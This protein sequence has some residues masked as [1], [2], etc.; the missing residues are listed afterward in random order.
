MRFSSYAAG[1][2]TGAAMFCLAPLAHADFAVQFV[3]NPTGNGIKVQVFDNGTTSI[4]SLNGGYSNLSGFTAT[5]SQIK[6]N[7]KIDGYQFNVT[8]TSNEDSNPTNLAKVSLA[9]TISNVD[10]AVNRNFSFFASD[11]PFTQ[12]AGTKG[13]LQAS[14]TTGGTFL[15]GDSVKVQAKYQGQ[16]GNLSP[17][18]PAVLT[19]I[20]GPATA[21]GQT[22]TA[23]APVTLNSPFFALADLGGSVDV[24]TNTTGL[25][26]TSQAVLALPE[27]DGVLIG[28]LGLPCMG[29]VVFFARRR[30]SSMAMVA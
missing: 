17:A 11:S 15:P 12:L 7:V 4:T 6:F 1:L 26:F 8:A 25:S 3:D 21:S 16:N 13:N 14:L 2:L 30:A 19:G 5:D 24:A 20:A 23:N 27:P 22:F 28:M 18:G 29:L 10:S 9:A